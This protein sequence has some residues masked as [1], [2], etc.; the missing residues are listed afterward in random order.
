M[1]LVCAD[2]G[3]EVQGEH[4]RVDVD[5]LCPACFERLQRGCRVKYISEDEFK[6]ASFGPIDRNGRE[7]HL[8]RTAR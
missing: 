1:K 4:T 6:K 7:V 5:V 2:C 3:V 8:A